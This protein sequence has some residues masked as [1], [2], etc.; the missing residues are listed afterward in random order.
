[1][2]DEHVKARVAAFITHMWSGEARKEREAKE[3]VRAQTRQC[4]RTIRC[5]QDGG[6]THVYGFVCDAWHD[7]VAVLRGT[8]VPSLL[9]FGPGVH[10]WEDVD[11]GMVV[12]LSERVAT[13]VV[14]RM[15]LLD[16][17][18]AADVEARDGQAC[19]TAYL[20]TDKWGSPPQVSLLAAARRYT[21]HGEVEQ[22]VVMWATR[23]KEPQLSSLLP[24]LFVWLHVFLA[25]SAQTH[26]F[27][28]LFHA[29][30]WGQGEALA[31]AE[32][33]LAPHLLSRLQP[34]LATMGLR[35]PCLPQ[36]L[37]PHLPPTTCGAYTVFLDAVHTTATGGTRP[38]RAPHT[39]S[40][41]PPG[42]APPKG[43]TRMTTRSLLYPPMYLGPRGQL[44]FNLSD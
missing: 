1:M 30:A 10:T 22:A 41:S 26:T 2:R 17:C 42:R 25:R 9:L 20:A 37:A 19:V 6:K 35:V 27:H 43:W 36:D 4:R 44:S 39:R 15:R 31:L 3:R 21:D 32:D 18:A 34:H 7:T 11:E 38:R 24:H 40:R 23:L 16:A 8:G 13:D 28:P 14:L 12:G 29:V 33:L 5:E